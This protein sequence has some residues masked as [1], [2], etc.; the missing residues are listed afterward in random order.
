M[1][2]HLNVSMSALTLLQPLAIPVC[3][4]TAFERPVWIHSPH[5]EGAFA[6]IWNSAENQIKGTSVVFHQC[7]WL[8]WFPH[9]PLWELFFFHMLLVFCSVSNTHEI[10]PLGSPDKV[11]CGSCLWKFHFLLNEAQKAFHFNPVFVCVCSLCSMCCGACVQVRVAW[12][13][14][15][16]SVCESC[17]G[18]DG[19][20]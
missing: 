14:G 15:S 3:L 2:T 1:R 10:E 19:W 16:F 12:I 5:P 18:S 6:I 9:N 20:L 11:R 17:G 8:L 4:G 7:C 13:Q